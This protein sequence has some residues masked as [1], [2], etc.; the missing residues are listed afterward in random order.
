[1]QHDESQ[2]EVRTSSVLTADLA[3]IEAV[4]ALTPLLRRAALSYLNHRVESDDDKAVRAAEAFA[5]FV[6]RGSR[7]A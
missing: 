7:A 2:L 3:A 1:M 6:R 5:Q 4:L